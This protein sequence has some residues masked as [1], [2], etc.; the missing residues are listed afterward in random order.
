LRRGRRLEL[1]VSPARLAVPLYS[2]TQVPRQ[3]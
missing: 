3:K 1:R 2:D